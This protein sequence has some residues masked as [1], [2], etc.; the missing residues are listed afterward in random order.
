M[1]NYQMLFHDKLMCQ[2]N[3]FEQFFLCKNCVSSHIDT[4]KYKWHFLESFFLLVNLQMLQENCQHKL[5][6]WIDWNRSILKSIATFIHLSCM[7]H[8]N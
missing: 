4:I 5:T 1:E 7:Q 3:L 2:S 8:N 6:E